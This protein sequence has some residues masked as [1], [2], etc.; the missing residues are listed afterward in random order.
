[1]DESNDSYT[2]RYGNKT[3]ILALPNTELTQAG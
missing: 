2:P 3:I 1:M